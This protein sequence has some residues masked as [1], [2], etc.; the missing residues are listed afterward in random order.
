VIWISGSLR[1][2]LEASK[3]SLH[4]LQP[5]IRVTMGGETTDD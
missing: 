4:F 3:S 2:R 1:G 5:M